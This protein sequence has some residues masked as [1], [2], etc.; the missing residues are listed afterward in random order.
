MVHSREKGRSLTDSR[1]DNIEWKTRAGSQAKHNYDSSP[2]YFAIEN[3][4]LRAGSEI[5]GSSSNHYA[6]TME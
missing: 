4:I 5:F 6:G 2:I 1:D 3:L